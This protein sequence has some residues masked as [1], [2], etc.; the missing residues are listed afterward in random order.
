MKR[1]TEEDGLVIEIKA[2]TGNTLSY[3][4]ATSVTGLGT[5]TLSQDNMTLTYKMSVDEIIV[6]L[7]NS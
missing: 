3:T 4:P 1:F 7:Y 2:N 5:G 6:S